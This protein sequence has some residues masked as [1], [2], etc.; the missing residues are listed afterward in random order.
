MSIDCDPQSGNPVNYL[1]L[2]ADAWASSP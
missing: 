1:L 2:A